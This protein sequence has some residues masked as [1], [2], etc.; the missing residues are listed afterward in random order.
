MVNP[1]PTQN[2]PATPSE[3]LDS[4]PTPLRCITGALIAGVFAV[5][6]YWITTS[7]HQTLADTPIPSTS[8]MAVRI[9]N[10]VRSLVVGIGAL[11][12]ITF[13][14]TTVGLLGLSIQLLFKRPEPPASSDS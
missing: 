7:I 4:T 10:L 13:S 3:T 1:E 5:G 6:M 12:T 2:L 8:L 14:V 11:G 9:S